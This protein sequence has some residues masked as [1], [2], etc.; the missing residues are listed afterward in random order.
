MKRQQIGVAGF[1]ELAQSAEGEINT[2]VAP[3][4][5]PAG[6]ILRAFISEDAGEIKEKH[7][8]HP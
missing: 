2:W 5:L 8:A 7:G 4:K 1:S 3:R 6:W